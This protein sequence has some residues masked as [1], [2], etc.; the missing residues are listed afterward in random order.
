MFFLFAFS[1]LLAEFT[2]ILWVI[3]LNN[4]KSL[5]YK[6]HSRRTRTMLLFAVIASQNQFSLLL[7]GSMTLQLASFTIGVILEVEALSPSLRRILT[8]LF[9]PKILNSPKDLLP[10]FYC[11]AFMHLGQLE[12]FEI[13]WIFLKVFLDSN[14]AILYNFLES[15]SYN[16]CFSHLF[17]CPVMFEAV[18]FLS[19]KLETLI[20]FFSAFVVTFSQPTFTLSCFAP[21]PIV[22]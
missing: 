15:S 4:Y 11:L 8:L 17:S 3:T 14:S 19:C 21:F 1:V 13:V 18:S 12:P 22:S 5:S 7:V 16:G 6:P 10:L 9:H 20:K 2:I